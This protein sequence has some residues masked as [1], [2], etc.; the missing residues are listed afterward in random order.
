MLKISLR[1]IS[2]FFVPSFLRFQ[3]FSF[4]SMLKQLLS[5]QVAFLVVIRLTHVQ[6]MLRSSVENPLP[7]LSAIGH[8]P[9][10]DKARETKTYSN[11]SSI[12]GCIIISLCKPIIS[13]LSL[14]SG[15]Y[16][17]SLET[18]HPQRKHVKDTRAD[19]LIST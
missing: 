14:I 5:P 6:C 7:R 18:C 4:L 12:G 9:S 10:S 3:F 15:T 16:T 8:Y 13:I 1:V 2:L 19:L 11:L 17:F